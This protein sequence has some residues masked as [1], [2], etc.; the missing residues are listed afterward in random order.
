MEGCIGI[1]DSK[2]NQTLYPKNDPENT[3]SYRI[4]L[5]VIITLRNIAG[6]SFFYEKKPSAHESYFKV[7]TSDNELEHRFGSIVTYQRP[8]LL[9]T[10]TDLEIERIIINNGSGGA[11]EP[12]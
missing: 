1:E 7:S 11:N 10:T 12:D 4:Q 6:Y 3:L 5:P 8:T 9:N 2:G